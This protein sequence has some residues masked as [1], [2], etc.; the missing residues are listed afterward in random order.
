MNIMRWVLLSVLACVLGACASVVSVRKMPTSDK[1]GAIKVTGGA[2]GEGLYYALPQTVV[3]ISMPLTLV[4]FKKDGENKKNVVTGLEPNFA[5]VNITTSSLPDPSQIYYVRIDRER[6]A[7]M[8]F[9]IRR[10]MFGQ[11]QAVGASSVNRASDVVAQFIKYSVSIGTGFMTGGIATALPSTTASSPAVKVYDVAMGEAAISQLYTGTGLK[12]IYK[13]FTDNDCSGSK[14]LGEDIYNARKGILFGDKLPQASADAI[15][16]RLEELK[17]FKR[18]FVDNCGV[19][20]ANATLVY[21]IVPGEGSGGKVRQGIV[22]QNGRIVVPVMYIN[23][24]SG[25]VQYINDPYVVISGRPGYD[26]NGSPKNDALYSEWLDEHYYNG[27]DKRFVFIEVDPVGSV[28]LVLK[29]SEISN[30]DGEHG[31]FYREPGMGRVSVKYK[32]D[33]IASGLVPVAQYGTILALPKSL[34]GKQMQHDILFYQDTGAIS[35]YA[36]NS[37]SHKAEDLKPYYESM[38][39]I[40]NANLKLQQQQK[41]ADAAAAKP[42]STTAAATA[43]P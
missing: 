30:L 2:P 34:H 27:I 19:K 41:T 6:F 4:P 26:K 7:D 3:R 18:E 22:D 37:A 28:G 31:F 20:T 13:K 32:G 9:M 43:T 42:A 10:S 38:A 15:K 33:V 11:V 23:E 14:K 21:D 39:E 5:D 40:L 29:N 25:Y 17:A 1:E 8:S 36:V 16:L 24:S 35:S 12:G